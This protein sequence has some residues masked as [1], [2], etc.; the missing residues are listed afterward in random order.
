[1]KMQTLRDR[2]LASSMI[3]GAVLAAVGPAYAADNA[4]EVT[5]IVVTGTRI[6]TPNLTS[7]SPVTAIGSAD[8][9][10]Q[11]VTRVEDM[12][13]SLPQAF[14]AQGGQ[15][16]NGS[17]GTATVNLRALGPTRTLVLIDGRRV[18][19]GNPASTGAGAVT[20]LNFIPSSL[21]ER[22]DVLTGGASAVYGADAV[23]GVVNFIMKKDFEGVKIDAQWSTY[24][25]TQHN[26]GVAAIVRAKAATATDPSQF[27]LPNSNVRDGDGSE[28]TLTMGVNAPDGKGNI[29]A[30]ASFRQINAVLEA[31]RD[32]SACTLNSGA[33]FTCGGSGTATPARVGGFTVSGNTFRPRD[34]IADV[35]NFGPTNFFQRPDERYTLGAFA[36]Y[37]IADWAEAYSQVM[38]M[39]DNSVAQIAPGG[40]FAGSFNI[41]C[42]NALLTPT[43]A[44]QLCGANAGDPTKVFNGTVAKRNVE[45]GGRLSGFRNVSYRYVIGLKGNLSDNW[46]YD[47]YLDYTSTTVEAP[48]TA[49][50]QTARIQNSLIVRRNAAG[51][52]VCQS[53]I[54]G[55]DPAC[56]PYNIFQEGKVTQAALNYLQVPSYRGGNATERVANLTFGGDLTPYGV[57]SPW[58]N[59]GVGVA[60]GA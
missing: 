10:A 26:D 42:D 31:N 60:F 13:N 36:H 8:I 14:A 20:N 58:A 27:K 39:D 12:I 49:F 43:Q 52:I 16:S 30:Y 44:T 1:M 3:C 28:I 9:K 47:A 33:V 29:T 37:Q 55:S 40:I 15:I 45:G 11:G 5:E 48:Q 34:P 56:V 41:N 25:H 7:V 24:Q 17:N 2:L 6:P 4:T 50:F 46:N 35:Y 32:F 53:V 19:P 38:F 51:Q 23:A 57:K 59:D 22:V 21:V 54:D 18:G